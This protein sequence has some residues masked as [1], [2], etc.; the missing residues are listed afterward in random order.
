MTIKSPALALV[1]FVGQVCGRLHFHPLELLDVR[2]ASFW[3]RLPTKAA[4]HGRRGTW[5]RV[6]LK[7]IVFAS[8]R[9]HGSAKAGGTGTLVERC[10][11][12]RRVLMIHTSR[13]LP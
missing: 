9:T 5:N 6:S 11:K 2:L 3:T 1:I 10:S 12:Q 13:V 8:P 4:T 7:S